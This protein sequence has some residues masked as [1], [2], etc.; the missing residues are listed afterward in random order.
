MNRELKIA[1]F[2]IIAHLLPNIIRYLGLHL[3]RLAPCVR[4]VS[5]RLPLFCRLATRRGLNSNSP[6]AQYL[7]NRCT[8]TTDHFIPSTLPLRS[9]LFLFRPAPLGLFLS[10]AFFVLCLYSPE[11]NSSSNSYFCHRE[12][13][14]NRPSADK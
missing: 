1:Q 6:C 14:T 8:F 11:I 4:C 3:R 5:F 12:E 7:L 2:K 9:V 13:A 10:L